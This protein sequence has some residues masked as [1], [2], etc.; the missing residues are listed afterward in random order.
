MNMVKLV[1]ENFNVHTLYIEDRDSAKGAGGL[2]F[3]NA[4]CLG[5][6]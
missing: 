6:I 5:A 3:A 2:I 4:C 1:L